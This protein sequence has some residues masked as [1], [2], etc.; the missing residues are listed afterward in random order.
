MATARLR[1]G[2]EAPST[3]PGRWQACVHRLPPARG[4]T[5]LG[6]RRSQDATAPRASEVSAVGWGQ[7]TPR[8]SP[9]QTRGP[10]PA[11]PS[12]ATYSR[13]RRPAVPSRCGRHRSTTP[14]A[15]RSRRPTLH[16]DGVHGRPD[17]GHRSTPPI[18]RRARTCAAVNSA[19]GRPVERI[20]DSTARRCCAFQTSSISA[21]MSLQASTRRACSMRFPVATINTAAA[22]PPS[23]P[24][25]QRRRVRACPR[26]SS[27]IS[28]ATEGHRSPGS[29]ERPRSQA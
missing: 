18:R 11:T 25:A 27:V 9:A 23:A 21:A 5:L 12:F 19:Y 8:G 15:R 1:P 7:C 20:A 4:P 28:A 10:L 17:D 3:G 24:R 14:T 29:V 13:V 6:P 22:V 26:R 16:R 2:I